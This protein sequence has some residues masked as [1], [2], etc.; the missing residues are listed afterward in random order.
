MSAEEEKAKG[1]AAMAKQNFELAA[2]HYTNAIQLDPNNHILYS[3]RSA[4]YASLGKYEEALVD[5]EKTI[6]LSP[7]FSKGYSRK[8]L[9]LFKLGKAQE[10]LQT[11][12]EGLKVEPGNA[13]LLEAVREVQAHT[14]NAGLNMFSQLFNDPS[15][16]GMIASDPELTPYLQQPDFLQMIQNVRT[17]PQSVQLYMQDPRFM[18]VVTKILTRQMN[19]GGAPGEESHGH[20]HGGQ[21]CTG[22]EAESPKPTQTSEPA[23]PAEPEPEPEPEPVDESRQKALQE[24]ELG[25]A[26]YKK[27]DFATAVQHYNNAI[28]LDST[29]MAFVTNRAAAHFEWGKYEEC[30]KDCEEAIQVGRS[31]RASFEL[32]AKAYARIGSAYRKLGNLEK[33][34]EALNTSLTENRV[35]AVQQQLRQ[36]QLEKEELDRKN[37]LNPE[38]ALQEK[39]KGNEFFKEGKFPQAVACYSEAIKRDPS[40]A[41]LY[42]NRAAA[43]IKL[44][45]FREALKD[46]ETCLQLDP[47][48]IKAYKRMAIA[49]NYNKDYHKAMDAYKKAAVYAP[50]DQELKDGIQQCIY[51]INLANSNPEL[52][53]Q[54]QQRA[55]ADPEIQVILKNPMIN[56]LLENLGPGGDQQAAMKMLQDPVLKE[57]FDKLVASG[58]ISIA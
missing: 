23:K 33:A 13:A 58:A 17:N 44:A 26:A 46:C 30:I 48:N 34:I 24:K 28:Q 40:N 7:S 32:I 10:A 22:H 18:K 55:M 5:G 11:Y 12:Q 25:N 50:D 4:A 9:A 49:H 16:L 29:D 52:Q 36:F 14:A 2:Q 39:D 53:K 21:P 19:P 20:S 45:D 15:V 38:I 31:N 42:S 8:G 51:S 41:L 43:Y 3:N 57:S 27:K 6:A 54:R 1:N 47:T 56:R 37:Y 35:R